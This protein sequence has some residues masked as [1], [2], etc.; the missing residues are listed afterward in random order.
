MQVTLSSKGQLVLPAGVRRGL[1]LKPRARLN[2]EVRD[3]GVFRR[4]GDALPPFEPIDYVPAGSLK[5]TR[6]MIEQN[7][8][9]GEESL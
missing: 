6:R 9:F 1:K 7:R 3:V 4:H 5:V 8:L 2:L